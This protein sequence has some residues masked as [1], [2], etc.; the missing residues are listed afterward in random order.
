MNGKSPDESQL[1]LE[2]IIERN[3]GQR[4]NVL[5]M[6]HDMQLET[7]GH[8]IKQTDLK[9]LA[10]A[11]DLPYSELHSVVT[12]YSMFSTKPRGE[13][14]IRVCE[15]GP[16]ALLGA[17][18]IFDV[19]QEELN[20]DLYDTTDDGLF[21]LEPSSC[22]GICGVAPAMMINQETYGNLT[23]NRIREILEGYR[24]QSKQGVSA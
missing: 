8:Y 7:P 14:I 16:C 2:E 11:L 5:S 15:S 3:G 19:I 1:D 6:L 22:L 23:P 17:D 20:V 18:T 4:R 10:R 9:S 12:F 13:Y 24:A 21:T